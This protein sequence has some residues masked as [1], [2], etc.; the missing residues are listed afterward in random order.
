MQFRGHFDQ[1]KLAF[2][3]AN[4][5]HYK[6]SGKY[7][8]GGTASITTGNF[9]GRMDGKGGRDPSGLGRYTWHKIRGRGGIVLRI[10][11]FYR[12]CQTANGSSSISMSTERAHGGP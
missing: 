4:S 12:P 2:T 11:T 6:I 10:V 7:Q 8:V 9:V 3:V 5:I 1:G